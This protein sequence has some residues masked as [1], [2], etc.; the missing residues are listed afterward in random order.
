[1][2][3]DANKKIPLGNA[4]E[5]E[6]N[7]CLISGQARVRLCLVKQSVERQTLNEERVQRDIF[8]RNDLKVIQVIHGKG[9][10]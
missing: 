9:Q 3:S 4:G 5:R 1:M 2:D 10:G 7:L 8:I 6:K